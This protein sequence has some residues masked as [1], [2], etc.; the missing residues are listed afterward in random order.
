MNAFTP[1]SRLVAA[2]FS[3]GITGRCTQRAV[4]LTSLLLAIGAFALT[5]SFATSVSAQ[6]DGP[7][8]I[9][10]DEPTPDV[11]DPEID[12]EITAPSPEPTSEPIDDKAPP[13][14]SE[15]DPNPDP[16]D[17]VITSDP[18]DDPDDDPNDG[19]TVP[20][21][22]SGDPVVTNLPDTGAGSTGGHASIMGQAAIAALILVAAAL[23]GVRQSQSTTTTRPTRN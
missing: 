5:A 13:P 21:D 18:N 10:N 19:P 1:I 7:P 16:I 4:L 8:I 12:D 6:P 23:L 22:E 15:P 9:V 17:D 3:V 11:H 14:P 2:P 20:G